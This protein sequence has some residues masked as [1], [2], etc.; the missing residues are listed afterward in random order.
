[1]L[2]ERFEV[3]RTEDFFLTARLTGLASDF[4]EHANVGARI[5]PVWGIAARGLVRHR[6][7]SNP[8]IEPARQ[9]VEI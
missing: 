5:M 1:L 2:L 8:L 7:R 6:C 4:P 9:P 3:E